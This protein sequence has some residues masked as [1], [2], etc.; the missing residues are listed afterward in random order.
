MCIECS[1]VADRARRENL[2]RRAANN[3][4][5]KQY[6]ADNKDEFLA[7]CRKYYRDNHEASLLRMAE[8]R[9]RNPQKRKEYYAK[10]REAA[11]S[12]RKVYAIRN[13]EK[14]N[15]YL[16][17]RRAFKNSADGFHTSNEVKILFIKQGGHCAACNSKLIVSGPCK[18]HIDHIVPLSKGGSDWISNIQLLCRFCNC[19]KKD[20][21]PHEWAKARGPL[22]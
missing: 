1:R 13:R 5:S 7:K 17:R 8:F 10:N 18:Y 19:S 11:L 9:K 2:E 22:I 16:R 14:V 3:E 6:Y 21:L 12:Y 20:K 15:E 4:R